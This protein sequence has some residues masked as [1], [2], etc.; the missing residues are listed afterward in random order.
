MAALIRCDI[1][2]GAWQV[3]LFTLGSDHQTMGSNTYDVW[4]VGVEGQSFIAGNLRA[5]ARVG[6]GF[7]GRDGDDDD[8]GFNDG[9]AAGLGL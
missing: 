7:K 1:H 8:E 6:Y 5:Y 4:I 3:D 2:G 9:I